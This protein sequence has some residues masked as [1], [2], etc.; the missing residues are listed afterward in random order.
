MKTTKSVQ[1]RV[2]LLFLNDVT[3]EVEVS[4]AGCFDPERD[5]VFLV[6]E[7]FLLLILKQSLVIRLNAFCVEHNFDERHRRTQLQDVVG[8]HSAHFSY[9]VVV[10]KRI[11]SL[12]AATGKLDLAHWEVE[13]VLIFVAC[14]LLL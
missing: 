10:G 5:E 2:A 8:I 7:S 4:S 14:I 1:L 3:V 6:K 9:F 12:F 11:V 13:R